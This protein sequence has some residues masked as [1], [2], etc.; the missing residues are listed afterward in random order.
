M[1]V[2]QS[3]G[4]KQTDNFATGPTYNA[5]SNFTAG[6]TV[7]ITLVHYGAGTVNRV[8]G[9]TVSG[10]AAVK[11]IDVTDSGATNHAEIW[12]ASNVAGG[13][14]AV[15]I[16]VNS[17]SGQYLSCGFEEWD[18]IASSPLD[19][20]GTTGNT[21]SAAPSVTSASTTTQADEV[22]YALFL[23]YAGTNW[24][25]A[26]PPGSYTESWEEPNGTLHEAGSAAY[27]V[28]S[29]TGVQTATFATGASMSWIAAMATY[30][31]AGAASAPK[32]L[33]L[34]GVG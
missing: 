7:I 23:D 10:T 14:T 32:R 24:T 22:V 3:S 12:R 4:L 30:K 26:T 13:S 31:K 34:L 5:A 27:R 2:V 1:A 17:G 25:S 21:V 15:A 9:I 6:N 33:T 18:D 20:T 16:T 19:Q 11:D 28:I 8:T 29:A